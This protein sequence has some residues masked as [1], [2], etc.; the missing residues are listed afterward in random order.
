VHPERWWTVTAADQPVSA[1]RAS[2][3]LRNGLISL[4]ILV[5]LVAG[6]LAAVPGLK[7]VADEVTRMKPGWLVAAVGF[8]VL[9]CLSYV[10]AFM[11]VFDRAPIRMGA[12]IAL[13][14]LA[15][16]AAVSVG[17]VGSVAVGAW[18]LIDRGRD[19]RDVAERSAVLFLLTSAINVLTLAGVGLLLF[20]GV[21]PG[22]R[23]WL[24]SLL[25]GIVGAVTFVFFL[26]LPR[27][28]DRLTH[29]E[30][31]GRI[32]KLL[33][34]TAFSIRLTEQ[35]LFS[36]DWRILGAI[37]YLWFDML[38]LVACFAAGG[39][40]PPLATVVLAYQIGYLSNMIPIPGGI[41]VLDGSFIA[42]FALYGVRASHAAAATLVYHGISLWVPAMWG[43]IAFVLLRKSRGKPMP[44]RPAR[45]QWP[46]LELASERDPEQGT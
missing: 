21:L 10:L 26:A 19:K 25:P 16:G 4:V 45:R 28:M 42:L 43:T 9:S 15:F 40:V 44:L 31:P 3:N 14:E 36:R 5:A 22:P 37:G 24:L 8:E 41:G 32:R 34:E 12:R 29:V 33:A 13:S 2:R 7:G 11:Q 46:E 17:G 30:H 18:L 23:N 1:A 38:V 39:T 6:L 35:I 27:V 20:V